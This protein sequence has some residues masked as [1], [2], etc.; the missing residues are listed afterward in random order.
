M[1]SGKAAIAQL[2]AQRTS[3]QFGAPIQFPEK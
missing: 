1:A 2:I 3:G